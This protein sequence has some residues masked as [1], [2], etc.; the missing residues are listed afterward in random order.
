MLR[1][2]TKLILA[3]LLQLSGECAVIADDGT[4]QL[5]QAR[6]VLRE[7]TPNIFGIEAASVIK[8]DEN[9]KKEKLYYDQ[10]NAI[11]QL[12]KDPNSDNADDII[13]LIPF[14]GYGL[15][16]AGLIQPSHPPSVEVTKKYFPA[17]YS[18]LANPRSKLVLSNYCLDPNRSINSR[19][20][21]FLVLR[22]VDSSEFHRIA[23]LVN[24]ILGM[25]NPKI[26]EKLNNIENNNFFF[27]G[28][29]CL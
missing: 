14:L 10:W 16:G 21:A 3:I 4:Q 5:E 1:T 25:N 7:T 19:L 23:P 29:L 17:F 2:L 11:Q 27:W 9:L 13:L 20:T 24:N 15:N 18:I 6:A 22:Y 26:I 8:S 28:Q 12:A